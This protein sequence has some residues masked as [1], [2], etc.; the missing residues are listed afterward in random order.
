[1]LNRKTGTPEDEIADPNAFEEALEIS[2]LYG[3]AM[4]IERRVEHLELT[5]MPLLD[6]VQRIMIRHL[7]GWRRDETEAPAAQFRS[8]VLYKSILEVP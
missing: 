7:I 1:M 2:D 4:V 6:R 3:E 5:L 8:V